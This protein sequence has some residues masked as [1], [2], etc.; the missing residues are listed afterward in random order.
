MS[1]FDKA[2]PPGL[3]PANVFTRFMYGLK[4]V[5]FKVVIYV[6]AKARTLQGGRTAGFR[7]F[8]NAN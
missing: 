1:Q 4:P 5:P 2:F 7:H 3:K 6:R 8:G